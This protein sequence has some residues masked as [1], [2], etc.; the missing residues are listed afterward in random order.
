[1]Q[2]RLSQPDGSLRGVSL[3]AGRHIKKVAMQVIQARLG[4]TRQA[5]TEVAEQRA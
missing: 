4:E 2:R 3:N 5:P 1:M